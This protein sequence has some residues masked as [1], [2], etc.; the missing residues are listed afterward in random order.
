[1]HIRFAPVALLK[2]VGALDILNLASIYPDPQPTQ[3]ANKYRVL[4]PGVGV[5]NEFLQGGTVTDQVNADDYAEILTRTWEHSFT[6]SEQAEKLMSPLELD[7]KLQNAAAVVAEKVNTVAMLAI[8]NQ[9]GLATVGTDNVDVTQ[10]NL[11]TIKNAFLASYIPQQDRYLI[12]SGETENTLRAITDFKPAFQYSGAIVGGQLPALESFQVRV[13]P[14]T[15]AGTAGHVNLAIHKGSIQQVFVPLT[16]DRM[17]NP[18]IVAASVTSNGVTMTILRENAPGTL[19][20]IRY[21]VAVRH[22]ISATRPAGAHLL[23][24]K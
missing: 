4:K 11:Q 22:G 19:G 15:K 3:E 6:L 23:L 2:L 8:S 9:A 5:A 24:G 12:I 21:S 20:A 13:S 10:A 1:L 18:G 16:S 7:G 14:Y 17:S